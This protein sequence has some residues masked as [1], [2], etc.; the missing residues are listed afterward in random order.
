MN[1]SI[2][3]YN[4]NVDLAFKGSLQVST[5]AVSTELKYSKK[6]ENLISIVAGP[7][8]REGGKLPQ[9]PRGLIAPNSSR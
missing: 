2:R 8:R 5:W 7:P 4:T 9:G 3:N 6:Q 1:T